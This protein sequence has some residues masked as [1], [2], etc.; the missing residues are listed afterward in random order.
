MNN[1]NAAEAASGEMI[2]P[3]RMTTSNPGPAIFDIHDLVRADLRSLES[4]QLQHLAHYEFA[5]ISDGVIT[6]TLSNVNQAIQVIHAITMGHCQ[7]C[8]IT[9]FLLGTTQYPCGQ[10]QT[11]LD[12]RAQ[13]EEGLGFRFNCNT[14]PLDPATPEFWCANA[15]LPVIYT[16]WGNPTHHRPELINAYLASMKGL[17]K[18]SGGGTLEFNFY[19]IRPGLLNQEEISLSR[20]WL[21][22][23]RN[24]F[25]FDRYWEFDQTLFRDVFFDTF[26]DREH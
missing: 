9:N 16:G 20:N 22:A 15:N 7:G 14:N 4:Q 26:P 12:C 13:L 24:R 3:D 25:Q 1:V 10:P 17:N 18:V 6:P 11:T 23:A 21:Q 2:T 19:A 8:D 5:F